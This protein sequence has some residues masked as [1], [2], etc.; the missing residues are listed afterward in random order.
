MNE[1]RVISDV[2]TTIVASRPM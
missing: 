2:T 1:Y